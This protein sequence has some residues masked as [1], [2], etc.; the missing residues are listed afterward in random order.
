MPVPLIGVAAAAAARI[1]SQ[2]LAQRAVG[3]I[4]G[5]GAK[6]I[7]KIYKQTGPTKSQK[8]DIRREMGFEQDEAMRKIYKEHLKKMGK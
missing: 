3:G 6:S 1:V 5:A 4:T 8:D 7:Q 2:K